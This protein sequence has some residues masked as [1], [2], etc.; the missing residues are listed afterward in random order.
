MSSTTEHV[1]PVHDLLSVPAFKAFFWLTSAIMALALAGRATIR[2][3]CFRKLLFEDALMILALSF[4][5]TNSIIGTLYAQDLY[6]LSHIVDGSFVPGPSFKTDTIQAL[7]GFVAT[8]I[9]TYAGLWAIKL[10]FLMFFYRLGYQLPKFRVWWWFIFSFVIASGLVQV[11]IIEYR[12]FLSDI[13]TILATCST[14]STLYETRRRV[15]V[16]VTLDIVSDFLMIV[17]PIS[18]FWNSRLK[19]RQKIVLSAVF[20]LVGFA[21][22]VTI[23]RGGFSTNL[24]EPS[25][26]AQLNV[27]FDFWITL[28]YFISFLIACAVSFR[29]LFVQRRAKAS[30]T[31]GMQAR[32]QHTPTSKRGP[33]SGGL[34]ARMRRWQESFLD[35]CYELEGSDPGFQMRSLPRPASGGITIDFS[36]GAEASV[37]ATPANIGHQNLGHSTRVSYDESTASLRPIRTAASPV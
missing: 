33:N 9:L 31:S 7:R 13:D 25:A 12:C 14:L 32:L 1:K 30:K 20:S 37:W 6:N 22:A 26:A 19:L 8:S 10:S 24:N 34:G 15:I 23:I 35:T 11:G 21:I 29:S 16:S 17:F 27:A 4:Y 5:I 36:H 3:V 18:I 2:I 28:E